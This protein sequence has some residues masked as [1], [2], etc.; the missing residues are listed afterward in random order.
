MPND[1][2]DIILMLGEYSCNY[3]EAIELYRFPN[4]QYPNDRIIA[5]LVLH[6][7]QRLVQKRQRCRI[8]RPGRI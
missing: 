3:Q 5:R 1:I 8:N 6:Q 7:R 4:R 2:V